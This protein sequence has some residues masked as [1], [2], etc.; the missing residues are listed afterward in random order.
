MMKSTPVLRQQKLHVVDLDSKV[1]EES[2]TTKP[3]LN[4]ALNN[5]LHDN[6]SRS[7]LSTPMCCSH[8][9]ELSTSTHLMVVYKVRNS[10][11][12]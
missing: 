2:E 10:R 8:H 6:T 1:K 5:D 11:L 3:Q 9:L 7:S 4:D 12:D